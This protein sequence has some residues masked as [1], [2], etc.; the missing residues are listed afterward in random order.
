MK[1]VVVL[2]IAAIFFSC[3][4][5]I[6]SEKTEPCTTSATG[7]TITLA[8]QQPVVIF[9]KCADNTTA[10]LTSINDSR[11]PKDVQCV[12][13][14]KATVQLQLGGNFNVS[15]EVGK[16]IDTTYHDKKYSFLLV[17]VMPYP[18]A[19]GTNTLEQSTAQL[20]IIKSE[21][22]TEADLNKR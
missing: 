21:R 3:G 10:S 1:Y 19:G 6:Y 14:G 4:H 7:D 15:L 17:D 13:A 8:Y 5:A 18:V 11:C 20:R 9:E 2:A 12:W 22:L 16:Q